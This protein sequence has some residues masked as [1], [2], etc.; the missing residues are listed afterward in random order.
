MKPAVP[1]VAL[2]ASEPLNVGRPGAPLAQALYLAGAMATL[3]L[4]CAPLL[5]VALLTGF[6]ARRFYTEVMVRALSR[7][8]LWGARIRTVV[9]GRESVPPGQVVYMPNHPS[10]LDVFLLTSLGLPETRYFLSRRVLRFLPLALIAW[11]MGVFFTPDQKDTPARVRLFQRALRHLQRS[12]ESIVGSPE[13]RRT[14]EGGIGR[15]NRGVFHLATLLGRPIVPIYIAFPDGASPGKGFAPRRAA[16]ELHFLPA[17]ATQGWRVEDI[18]RNKESV[19]ARF[20]AFER[21]LAA[22]RARAGR[23]QRAAALRT[24]GVA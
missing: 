14:P 3:T 10:S 9:R 5:V 6:R 17:I 4:F 15:F 18:D 19:R 22:Q 21:E 12:G 8:V 24:G 13:G 1:P 11:T 16:V 2:P 23:K 7:F 20:V